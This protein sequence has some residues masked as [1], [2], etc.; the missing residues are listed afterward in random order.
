MLAQL[1]VTI[2]QYEYTLSLQTWAQHHEKVSTSLAA[3]LH[4]P[5]LVRCFVILAPF[6]WILS[7]FAANLSLLLLL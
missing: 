5:A 6:F 2:S 1:L 3:T 7:L 4:R